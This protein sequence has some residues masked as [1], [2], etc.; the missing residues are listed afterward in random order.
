M[1]LLMKIQQNLPNFESRRREA[2]E[3]KNLE[4]ADEVVEGLHGSE[5]GLCS[6]L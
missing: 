1:D 3:K 5:E 2:A 6:N 4:D